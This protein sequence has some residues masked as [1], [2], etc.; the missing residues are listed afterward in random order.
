[1]VTSY[2]TAEGSRRERNPIGIVGNSLAAHFVA[3]LIL[4]GSGQSQL[5]VQ[6]QSSL[7]QLQSNS[8][9]NGRVILYGDLGAGHIGRALIIGNS[10]RDSVVTGFAEAG[11]GLGNLGASTPQVGGNGAIAIGRT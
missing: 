9:N 1:M 3:I 4:N 2:S 10:D 8:G 6:G 11:C 7:G 5:L